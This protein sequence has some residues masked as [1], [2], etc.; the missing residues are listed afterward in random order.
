MFFPSG[1]VVSAEIC[2]VITESIAKLKILFKDSNLQNICVSKTEVSISM[3]IDIITNIHRYVRLSG[4]E[5]TVQ[6][7]SKDEVLS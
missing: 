4:K 6:D 2:C 5:E 7:A 1:N 3:L